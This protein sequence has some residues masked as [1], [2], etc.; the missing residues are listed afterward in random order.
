[1]RLAHQPALQQQQAIKFNFKST[2][3]DNTGTVKVSELIKQLQEILKK[4]G[5]L[6]VFSVE[7][8][9]VTDVRGA[10]VDTIFSPPDKK[11]KKKE[12]K[13]VVIE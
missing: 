4:E 6:P 11:K 13:I 12:E 2:M 9:G 8:G 5:D 10:S 7:F 1:M 3:D